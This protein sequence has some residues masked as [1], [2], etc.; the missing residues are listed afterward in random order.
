MGKKRPTMRTLPSGEQVVHKPDDSVHLVPQNKV[1][2]FLIASRQDTQEKV[3]ALD[4][5]MMQAVQDK[6]DA[7]DAGDAVP[8]DKRLI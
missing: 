3:A 8:H 1:A 5:K 7:M 4:I 2:N 6:I